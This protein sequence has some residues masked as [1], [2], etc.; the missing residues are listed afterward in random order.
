MLPAGRK[1]TC[2]RRKRL[3]HVW[4]CKGFVTPLHVILAR[5][6]GVPLFQRRPLS[7]KLSSFL[8]SRCAVPEAVATLLTTLSAT[9]GVRV[10]G[11]CLPQS[12][13]AMGRKTH[14]PEGGPYGGFGPDLP[15]Y[16]P[17]AHGGSDLPTGGSASLFHGEAL[18]VSALPRPL[19]GPATH[20][21]ATLRL[22]AGRTQRPDC[23]VAHN[24]PNSLHAQA[25][26]LGLGS[27]KKSSTATIL[28]LAAFGDCKSSSVSC[29][30]ETPARVPFLCST[31]L[32]SP[33]SEILLDP[34]SPTAI[35]PLSNSQSCSNNSHLSMCS[36]ACLLPLPSPRSENFPGSLACP[37]FP[38]LWCVS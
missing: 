24:R 12:R 25:S 21:V 5:V 30:S 22:F 10:T 3:A 38:W 8:T 19:C 4:R 11:S 37:Y 35:H 31:S 17:L 32:L 9:Q 2:K 14:Q 1:G 18:R 20:R 28:P 16:P 13:D 7:H 33:L 6:K 34:S 15:C 23:G 26:L 36:W 29:T 27:W